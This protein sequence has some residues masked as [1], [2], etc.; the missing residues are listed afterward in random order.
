MVKRFEVYMYDESGIQK[1]CLVISPNEMNDAL[2]YVMIAPITTLERRLPCRVVI[3][4]KGKRGQI[5]LDMIKTVDKRQLP[6]KVGILPEESHGE[7][8]GILGKI[9]SR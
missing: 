2:P 8:L 5:A 7:I 6:Q 3:G 1:P 4:L 9:F